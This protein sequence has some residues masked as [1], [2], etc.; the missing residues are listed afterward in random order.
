[1]TQLL[2]SVRD[3]REAQAALVGGADVIDIKEPSRGPLGAASP[4]VWRRVRAL[5]P[6]ALVSA[7]L[8]ELKSLDLH[9]IAQDVQGLDYVKVGLA[10]CARHSSWC[11]QWQALR[12]ALPRGTQ[13]VAVVYADAHAADAPSCEMVLEMAAVLGLRMLLFDTYDKHGGDVFAAQ[14]MHMLRVY[15]AMAH[16][17]GMRVALAGSLRI[18]TLPRAIALRPDI[19]AVR[20]AACAGQARDGRV[21]RSQVALLRKELRRLGTSPNR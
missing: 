21:V 4:A 16:G 20:G 7:A 1:M 5:S 18:S 2:V 8:G 11:Q 19:V 17:F 9:N 10:G 15:M 14:S 3:V 6:T 12:D 13:L